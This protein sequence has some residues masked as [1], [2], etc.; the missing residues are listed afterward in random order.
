MSP[1]GSPRRSAAL[2]TQTCKPTRVKPAE[3]AAAACRQWVAQTAR[4][5]PIPGARVESLRSD[6]GLNIRCVLRLPGERA[7]NH[8]KSRAHPPA[9]GGTGARR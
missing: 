9:S 1:V 5:G 8:Q 7:Q 2:Q 6:I 3:S 4:T